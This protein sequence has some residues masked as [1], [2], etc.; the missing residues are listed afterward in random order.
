MSATAVDL[1][2]IQD[3]RTIKARNFDVPSDPHDLCRLYVDVA[4]G[5]S[6]RAETGPNGE[7]D[8]PSCDVAHQHAD[9]AMVTLVQQA[10]R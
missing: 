2:R 4:G 5:Q 10:G 3:Y 8:L 7:D 9:A 6:L 1:P